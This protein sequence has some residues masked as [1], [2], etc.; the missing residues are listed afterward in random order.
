M[1][2]AYEIMLDPSGDGEAGNRRA[3]Q[4]AVLPL[5]KLRGVPNDLRIALRHRRI[6]NCVQLLQIA[7]GPEGRAALAR[8]LRADPELILR[9][10]QRAD[11]SRIKGIG[12]IF[13]L[14]L[15]ELDIRDV[16]TLARQRPERLHARLKEYN[17]RERLARRS[18]TPEEIEDW[19]RQARSLQPMI[20]Y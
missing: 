12:A 9:L 7:G 8:A 6:T 15:E 13:G 19:I 5:S 20:S 16:Q 2:A 4:G 1:L 3:E 14:M 17:R 11:L 18:P 10:V